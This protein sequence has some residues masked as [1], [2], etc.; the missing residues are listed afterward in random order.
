MRA[1]VDVGSR[2]KR[3]PWDVARNVAAVLVCAG[4]L[5]SLVQLVALL[6]AGAPFADVWGML[7]SLV[8]Y[9]GLACY[10]MLGYRSPEARPFLAAI[11]GV[12]AMFF[13]RA[14]MP[15]ATRLEAACLTLAFALTL[16]FAERIDQPVRAR[17]PLVSA[18]V[19]LVVSA[20]AALFAAPDPTVPTLAAVLGR[21]QDWT[22]V[23]CAVTLAL[24][25]EE[26]E[27]LG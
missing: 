7:V 13:F 8:A 2:G 15:S 17:I 1:K 20:L 21:L 27:A 10:C 9:A 19:C 4:L 25:F 22:H 16:V 3:G 11:Y 6:H 12:A 26:R 14:L 23:V 24:A 18:I 5:L